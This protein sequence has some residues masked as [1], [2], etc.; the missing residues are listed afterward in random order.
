MERIQEIFLHNGITDSAP[1][2]FSDCVVINER[3]LGKL[4]FEPKSVCIG[5]LPYYT[6]FCDSPRI[7]SSY[8]LSFDYHKL[9]AS[10]KE[11][12]ISQ[13]TEILPNNHFA[14]FGDHSP[15]DEKDA[16]AKAGLGI[17]GMHSLL[18]TPKYSSFVFLFELLTDLDCDRL[19]EE[20][21]HCEHCGRCISACPTFLKGNGECL[22]AISQKKGTLSPIE[23]KHLIDANTAWGC[24][25][26]QL[27]CPHTQRAIKEK[28]IY[29][30]LDWFNS[31]ILPFPTEETIN[32]SLDF[33][34][35][36]Y[37]WR[38]KSTILRNINLLSH[39]QDE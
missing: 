27:A 9:I 14:V 38:G 20:V 24:D 31:N 32:N 33:Q 21:V 6:H 28:T 2:R 36:A 22:S 17:I 19:P 16:A 23:A 8:A 15:I 12:I 30:S 37:S 29:S 34:S 4:D 5:L 1:V 25:I 35:R 10:L 7:V 11:K 18:I 13:A 26:C 39:R 3:L